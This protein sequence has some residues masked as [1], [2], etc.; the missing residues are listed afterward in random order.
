MS[1]KSQKWW[2]NSPGQSQAGK[3][4][5]FLHLEEKNQEQTT[6]AGELLLSL[7]SLIKK[8]KLDKVLK[9]MINDIH[10]SSEKVEVKKVTWP[11]ILTKSNLRVVDLVKD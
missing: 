4:L 1:N 6:Y 8:N 2:E 9:A 10:K 3:F 5:N 7:L 11:I